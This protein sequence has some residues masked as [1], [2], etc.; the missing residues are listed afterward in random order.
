MRRKFLASILALCMI[1][2]L[3][4][5]TAFAADTGTASTTPTFDKT[6]VALGAANA[7]TVEFT[8][9]TKDITYTE[10]TATVK[11]Y[12]AATGD[13]VAVAVTGAIGENNSLTLTYDSDKDT[14]EAGFPDTYYITIDEDGEEAQEKTESARVALT[15]EE[16]EETSPSKTEPVASDFTFTAPTSLEY[17]GSAKT[18]TVVPAAGK[19]GMGE[20]TIEYYNAAGQKVPS[21]INAG[22]YTVKINVTEGDSY[23]AKDGL[24][25]NTWNFT[26]T[27]VELTPVVTLSGAISN[28]YNG[29]KNLSAADLAKLN[30]TFEDSGNNAVTVNSSDY[31]VTASYADANAETDKAITVTV[32]LKEGTDAKTNYTLADGGVVT[33]SDIKGTITKKEIESS[34]SVYL[35]IGSSTT[36]TVDLSKVPGLPSG[37]SFSF[38]ADDNESLTGFTGDVSTST[39]TLTSNNS[40]NEGDS[41][42]Y[43]VTG[44]G[45]NYVVEITV[46]VTLTSKEIKEITATVGAD[47]T[48]NDGETVAGIV[49]NGPAID[50]ETSATFTTT[51]EGIGNTN[52]PASTTAPVNAG[53]Y[54]V[55]FALSGDSNFVADPLVKEFEIKAKNISTATIT[56][57]K[58]SYPYDAAGVKPTD[59]TVKIGEKTLLSDTDYT[60]S[61]GENKTAGTNAGSVTVNGQGN[62]TG[63]ATGNF[64]IDKKAASVPANASVKVGETATIEVETDGTITLTDL[65]DTQK[66]TAT[67]TL[68]QATKTITVTGVAVGS[69]DLTVKADAGTNYT[70]LGET[71]VKV[72]VTSGSSTP[73]GSGGGS[74]TTPTP[75]PVEPDPNP[76]STGEDVTQTVTPDISEGTASATV[77]KETADKLVSDA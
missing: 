73:G 44:T 75:P 31:T 2:S 68:D 40:G 30:V 45:T 72:T 69:I 22:K 57:G 49:T 50:G 56:F 29:D 37:E 61:Y 77:D 28:E 19:T 55:T 60:L 13:D 1:M 32:A 7:T 27:Q 10:G 21:A 24:T 51:Y 14:E 12:S 42:T 5:M 35:K 33:G 43:M 62:Y 71:T 47:L 74:G 20:V 39:L 23:Q 3:L 66:A 38:T 18:A 26:I 17:N 48:Y 76:P 16:F 6:T 67:A 11:V 53:T 41:S 34:A 63:T 59:V 36:A 25:D 58:T 65:T 70:E 4:P 15:V 64:T 52:Y 54:K 8:L 46:T 9:T